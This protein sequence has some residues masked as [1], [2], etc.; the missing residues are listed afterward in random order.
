MIHF[1]PKEFKIYV[2]TLVT[3]YSFKIP[4][5]C[6]FCQIDEEVSLQNSKNTSNEDGDPA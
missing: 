1:Q 4:L 6:P 3:N 2:N 5:V